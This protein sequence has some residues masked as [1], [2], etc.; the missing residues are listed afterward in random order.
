MKKVTEDPTKMELVSKLV[1]DGAIDLSDALKLLEVEAEKEFVY[2]PFIQLPSYVQ[3]PFTIIPNPLPPL[4]WYQ[5]GD[6]IGTIGGTHTVNFNTANSG[7]SSSAYP[8]RNS[9]P[10][11]GVTTTVPYTAC[12]N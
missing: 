12:A 5:V 3:P 11:D 8:T 9:Y 1:K 6:G 4:P 2:V 7:V 10:I